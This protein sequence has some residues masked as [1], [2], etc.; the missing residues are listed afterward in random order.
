MNLQNEISPAVRE[1][2]GQNWLDECKAEGLH[3]IKDASTVMRWCAAYAEFRGF[4]SPF[5]KAGRVLRQRTGRFVRGARKTPG[6]ARALAAHRSDLPNWCKDRINRESP[7]SRGLPWI[8]YPALRFLQGV[9]KPGMRVFEWGSGGSTVFF[10]RKGCR[11]TSVESSEFW[12]DRLKGGLHVISPEQR[13]NI[14]LRF[15]RADPQEYPQGL[16]AYVASVLDGGPWDFVLVDGWERVR[17]AETAQQALAP[18]G[19]LVFDNSDQPQFAAARERLALQETPF[20]GLG[21]SRIWPTQ[22]SVYMEHLRS[23][24]I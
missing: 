19:I 5:V 11:V 1:A 9:V 10:A 24:M 16:D 21:V 14:D 6:L 23:R 4:A 22:T 15:I 7:I 13:S 3:P 2:L 18:D 17:C 8:S 20:P 12:H